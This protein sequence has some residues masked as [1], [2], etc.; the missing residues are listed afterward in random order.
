MLHLSVLNPALHTRIY[1]KLARSQ[2]R[3]GWKVSIAAQH[4]AEAP[5]D[6]EGITIYPI[7][8]FHRLSLKRLSIRS[9]F[10]Q[11]VRE[12][13]PDA[14][15]VHAPE[16]LPLA[17]RIHQRFGTKVWYDMHED[18]QLDILHAR[19][20]PGWLRGPLSRGVRKTEKQSLSF[21]DV[22]SYAEE[23]Y[24]DVLGA[25]GKALIL[26]NL[27]PQE[28]L[29]PIASPSSFPQPYF[30][31]SGTLAEER[32]VFAAIDLWERLFPLCRH[33]LVI[34]GQ[35]SRQ[36]FLDELQNRIKASVHSEHLTLIGGDRYVPYEEMVQLI[37][38]SKAGIG[39]YQPL[40]HLIGKLPTK[41]YEH[42]ALGVPLIYPDLGE[43]AR[44]GQ[45]HPLGV[46]ITEGDQPEKILARL[47]EFQ[48]AEEREEYVW[49]EEMVKKGLEKMVRL[50]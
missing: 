2:Q 13:K 27:A 24:H 45:R 4:E 43:W 41:F 21:L 25:G 18:Y 33:P 28:L 30:L 20:F 22:V 23:S 3:L 12:L 26:P 7:R 17:D 16:L 50:P 44:F 34:G 15:T 32:G 10:Y 35:S 46:G 37:R 40:P 6:Q 47:A 8:P 19:H 38:H 49:R 36:V 31:F 29:T 5:F 14:I 9:R 1:H 11:L 39:L 48:A 42:L